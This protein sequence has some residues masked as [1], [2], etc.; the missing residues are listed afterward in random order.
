MTAWKHTNTVAYMTVILIYI[1]PEVVLLYHKS[2]SSYTSFI[3]YGM[4]HRRLVDYLNS[5]KLSSRFQ[6][7]ITHTIRVINH[8]VQVTH[9]TK[10]CITTPLWLT[11]PLCSLDYFCHWSFKQPFFIFLNCFPV[12]NIY[13]VVR[14]EVLMVV[15]K[16]WLY[17]VWYITIN[18]VE[19][20]AASISQIAE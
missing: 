10:A 2:V 3:L 11:L 1:Q 8:Q 6:I 18:A 20:S 14:C 4:G 12:I 16:M 17:E 15:G 9:H 7:L 19:E 5:T 13:R